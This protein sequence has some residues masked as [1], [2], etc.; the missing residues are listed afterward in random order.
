MLYYFI[1]LLFI[2]NASKDCILLVSNLIVHLSYVIILLIR[3]VNISFSKG[4][5]IK[6]NNACIYTD[7]ALCPCFHLGQQTIF[8]YQKRK[9]CPIFHLGPKANFRPNIHTEV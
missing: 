1:N 2:L 3:L 5:T 6:K 9:L 8:F 4:L 7:F